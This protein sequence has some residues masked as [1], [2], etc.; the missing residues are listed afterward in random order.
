[1]QPRPRADTSKPLFP[2]LRFCICVF[3]LS[4][5]EIRTQSSTG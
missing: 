2:G 4:A 5:F 3:I 1:M